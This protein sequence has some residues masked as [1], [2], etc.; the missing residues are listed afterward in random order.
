MILPHPESDF[1]TNILI[2]SADIIKILK[3]K[4][5]NLL[6]DDTM[7]SFL[8]QDK[9]RTPNM[10]FNSLLFLFTVGIIELNGYKLTLSQ[11][12]VC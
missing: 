9:R 7:Q 4:K 11:R 5:G 10:F 6:I 8:N 2:I 1:K 3:K 12:K